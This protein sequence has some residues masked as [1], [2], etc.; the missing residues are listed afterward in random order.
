MNCNYKENRKI[1]PD[2][3]RQLCINQGWYASGSNRDYMHLLYEMAGEKNNLSTEDMMAIARDIIAHS[4]NLDTDDFVWV[5]SELN[6][7]TFVLITQERSSENEAAAK[8]ISDLIYE[9]L[10]HMYC[11]N[12]RYDSELNSDDVPYAEDRCDNC[13]RKETGWAVSRAAAD[14]LANRIIELQHKN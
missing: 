12:C 14:S 7:I 4:S 6:R 13:R 5:L 11:D 9:A 8:E 10:N 3:L 2:D 1:D